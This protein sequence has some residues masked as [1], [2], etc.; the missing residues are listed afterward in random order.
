MLETDP[1][2][3]EHL[4]SMAAG[5]ETSASHKTGSGGTT[6]QLQPNSLLG[7]HSAG[8]CPG[9]T[10]F[11]FP[12]WSGLEMLARRATALEEQNAREGNTEGTQPQATLH[13]CLGLLERRVDTSDSPASP[14]SS[15]TASAHDPDEL[16]IDVLGGISGSLLCTISGVDSCWRGR[17]LKAHIEHVTGVDVSRQRLLLD[18]SI[19]HDA[20]LLEELFLACSTTL[21]VSML[22][23]DE[24]RCQ[25]LKGLACREISFNDLGQEQ[26]E[27]RELALVAVQASQGRAL[28]HAGQALKKDRDL[29]LVAVRRNGLSLRHADVQLRQEDQ[30]VV[31]TAV[32]ECG[33][34]LEHVVGDLRGCREV[35]LCAVRGNGSAARFA[36]VALKQNPSLALEVVRAN[37]EA[38]PHLPEELFLDRG[39][40]LAV[41]EA[42]GLALQHLGEAVRR[43]VEAVLTAVRSSAQALCFADR[44]LLYSTSFAIQAVEANALALQYLPEASRVNPEVSAAAARENDAFL[45]RLNIPHGLQQ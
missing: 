42:N 14:R 23:I 12:A 41:L 32:Q 20:Q 40:M 16:C 6:A 35:V 22:Q 2:S 39:F 43:D 24:N 9:D 19:L 37:Y 17:D 36:R 15:E 18:S 44:G 33:L 21:Q 30:E 45:A 4:N 27:D 3:E 38:T 1:S 5:T 34:A 26:R 29:V 7:S 31:L 28:E 10:S 8:H 25:L 11:D 13:D